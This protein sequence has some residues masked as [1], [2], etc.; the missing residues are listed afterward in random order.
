M[1]MDIF[2]CDKCRTVGYLSLT[3][4]G[5]LCV[6]CIDTINGIPAWEGRAS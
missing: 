3:S 6:T 2:I 1:M 5:Y 4:V